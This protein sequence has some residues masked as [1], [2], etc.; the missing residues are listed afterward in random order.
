MRISTFSDLVESS[1]RLFQTT[2]TWQ[3]TRFALSAQ[4]N[5]FNAWFCGDG[6]FPDFFFGSETQRQRIWID[7]SI[8]D[9]V[10]PNMW[11]RIRW[12]LDVARSAL[13]FFSMITLFVTEFRWGAC[14]IAVA[15]VT[16]LCFYTSHVDI[17]DSLF[18]CPEQSSKLAYFRFSSPL[19]V[20]REKEKYCLQQ[21]LL[22]L[23]RLC[24]FLVSNRFNLRTRG[25]IILISLIWIRLFIN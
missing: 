22:L 23:D 18:P 10:A 25:P 7:Q 20:L 2:D 24:R 8:V 13:R 16:Q 12:F 6:L 21:L 5:S 11:T 3:E 17:I 9:Y 14:I 4:R 1:Y 19:Q 15:C